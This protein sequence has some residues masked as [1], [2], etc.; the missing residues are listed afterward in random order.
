[1]LGPAFLAIRFCQYKKEILITDEI[2]RIGDFEFDWDDI[3]SYK[4]EY[5]S[6]METLLIKLKNNRRIYLTGFVDG[7]KA[8]QFQWM[9][10]KFQQR[11]KK[12]NNMV[13]SNDKIKRIGLFESKFAKP[14][15]ILIIGLMLTGTVFLLIG[16]INKPQNLLF[17]MAVSIPV[18]LQIFRKRNNN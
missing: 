15:G 3:K 9:K 17:F 1:M 5:S 14:I 11:L 18:L 10:A 16:R 12:Y 8:I 4:L 2:I 6:Y 7:K 13:E